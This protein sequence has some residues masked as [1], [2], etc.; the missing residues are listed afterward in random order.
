MS[1]LD[2]VQYAH[3]TALVLESPWEVPLRRDRSEKSEVACWLEPLTRVELLEY[4]P[5]R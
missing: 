5:G 2:V 4:R 1:C 3:G